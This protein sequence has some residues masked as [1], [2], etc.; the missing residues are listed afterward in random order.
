MSTYMST[1]APKDS[2][3][4]IDPRSHLGLEFNKT[5]SD[6]L[7][8]ALSSPEEYFALRSRVITAITEDA[9]LAVYESYWSILGEGKVGGTQLKYT[10][11]GATGTTD[12]HPNLPEVEI[13]KFAMSIAENVQEIS[14]TAV[15]M[16]LP[17][18]Y[19]ELAKKTTKNLT[20]ARGVNI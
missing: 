2:N 11:K 4:Y 14:E 19:L 5:R 13:S 20:V 16:I 17:Q 7:A 15:Q 12:F 6:M 9:V 18:D 8:L 3:L 10:K 1:K